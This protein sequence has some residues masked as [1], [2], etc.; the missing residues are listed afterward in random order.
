MADAN[1]A[2]DTSYEWK[3]SRC[4]AWGSAWW[5]WTAGNHRYP[6][7]GL[8]L[9]RRHHGRHVGPHRPPQGSHSRHHRIFGA[10]RSL[11]HGHRAGQ[12]SHDSSHHGIDRA[13]SLVRDL[14]HSIALA[15]LHR[16]LRNRVALAAK[17]A[18]RLFVLHKGEA[19]DGGTRLLP[20]A[21]TISAKGHI[22]W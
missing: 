9:L 16:L 3:Q 2:W 7:A 13:P 12:P 15:V 18:L 8:G 20:T 17:S 4:W 5:G 6:G 14:A 19:V 22:Y 11:R 1:K 21:A 10:F